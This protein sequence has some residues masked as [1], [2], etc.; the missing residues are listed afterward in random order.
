MR[1]H[2]A[3]RKRRKSLSSQEIVVY[4]SNSAI[5]GT[6]NDDDTGDPLPRVTSKQAFAAFMDIQ[7]YLLCHGSEADRAYHIMRD[8][9]NELLTPLSNE[10]CGLHCS[11]L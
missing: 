9:E 11:S 2:Q 10:L 6:E 4:E 5:A 3:I 8:L 7:A 1:K